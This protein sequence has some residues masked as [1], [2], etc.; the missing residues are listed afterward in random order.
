VTLNGRLTHDGASAPAG[1]TVKVYR[2]VSGSS[3]NSATLTA[4]TAADGTFTVTDT[5]PGRGAYSYVAQYAGTSFYASASDSY[6]VHVAALK[7]ALKL[8]VSAGSVKPGRS[9]TVTATLGATHANRT[10]IIYAQIKGGRRKLIR[11]AT[12]N[13]KGQLRIV[14]TIKVNTTFSVAFSGDSWYSPA[15]ATAVVKA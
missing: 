14:Y 4:T 11:R 1:A 8:A 3:V 6:L 15:S 10:L 13:S 12:V 9:V 7:P 5:P 2:R